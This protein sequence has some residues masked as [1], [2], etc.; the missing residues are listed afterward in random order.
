MLILQGDKDIQVSVADERL[1]ATN[2]SAKL[3]ILP[4]INHVLKYVANDDRDANLATYA[5]P[6]L[7]LGPG[8]VDAVADFVAGRH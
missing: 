8:V 2:P 7:P 3:K 6:S 1:K 5:D 4:G